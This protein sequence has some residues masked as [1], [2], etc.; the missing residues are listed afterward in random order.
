M[1]IQGQDHLTRG[2]NC[3]IRGQSDIIKGQD[4]LT[5]MVQTVRLFDHRISIILPSKFWQKLQPSSMIPDATY[6]FQK[7]YPCDPGTRKEILADIM[8]WTTDI[9]DTARCFFWMSGDPGIGK[10]AITASIAKESKRRWVL[11]AQLFINCNDARTV[12]P[13]FFFPSIAQQMSKSSLAVK[14]AVQEILKE[15]GRASCRER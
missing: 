12:D 5:Q 9:S 13:H 7:K 4:N 14:Y 2:Q 8:D 6:E 1:L 10:S 11:W 3:L 15:I